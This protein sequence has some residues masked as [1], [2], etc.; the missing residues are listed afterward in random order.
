M[1][2]EPN[3]NDGC[4]GDGIAPGKECRDCIIQRAYFGYKLIG[5][6]WVKR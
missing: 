3:W 1:N 5:G 4:Q 6:K 2:G